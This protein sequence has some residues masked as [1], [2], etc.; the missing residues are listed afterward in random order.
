MLIIIA[1]PTAVGKTGISLELA[2]MLDGE[3]VSADSRQVY[4]FM[5][6]GTAKPS[7]EDMQR[8]PHHMIDVVNPD[9]EYTAADYMCGAHTAIKAILKKGKTPIMAGGSGLYIRA[10]IDGIFPGPGSDK[11]IREKLEMEAKTS[12]ISSLH[13]RLCKIDPIASSRIHPNDSRRIIRALEVYEITG[14]PISFFQKEWKK[15]EAMYDAVMVGLNRPREE[16]YGRIEERVDYIFEHGF[17]DEAKKLLEKGYEEN[18]VS[19]EALGY[20]EVIR[21]LKGEINI[22]AAKKKIKLDTRHYARRQLIWFR[23]DK[24]ITWFNIDNEEKP[25]ETAEKI[26]QKIVTAVTP[27]LR[28]VKQSFPTPFSKGG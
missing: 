9:E 8:I 13:D 17:V 16:L 5:D 6:I 28:V 10:V 4:R 14:K 20:R 21:F 1:G 3:I 19:M 12:G 22:D 27:Q 11:K 15:E 2:E 25:V 26:Y 18:L 24:R 23:K 7:A